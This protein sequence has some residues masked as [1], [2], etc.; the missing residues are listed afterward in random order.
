MTYISDKLRVYIFVKDSEFK[1]LW[2]KTKKSSP[3]N[4]VVVPKK[5][6]KKKTF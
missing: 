1:K 6:N 3:K 2:E 4:N 5:T